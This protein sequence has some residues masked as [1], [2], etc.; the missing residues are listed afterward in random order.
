MKAMNVQEAE[1][2]LKDLRAQITRHAHQYYVLDDP[3]ISDG[4]Y[5]QLFRELLDL[6]EQFPDL[7][8]PDSPSLRVGGEPL[9]AFAEAE[10]AV[11]MLSLDNVFNAQEL[12]DFEEKIQR[13]LQATTQPTYL[14][15]PKLDGLAV[16][17]IYE[18]G[19]LVQGSTRGNGLVGENITAQLQTVQ[20]IPL[21]LVAQEG[22]EDIAIP[23]KLVVRGE[24]FL[25]RKGFLQLN[26]Q[27]A[28]QGEA[29]FANPRNAA[30]GSLRQLDPK[31]TASRPLR[32]YV[33]GVGDTAPAPCADLEQLFSWL[34]Q[35]GF[36]V[37]SLIKFCS[38][39]AEV[40]EQYQHLQAIRHELEYEIDGMVIKVADFALQQRLGNTTRAPRWATAWKFP[41]TQA[42]TVMTGVDFQV[43]RTGA[44]TPVAIL[45][46]VAV[47][48]VIVRRATLHNQDE[49]ERKGLKIGDTVLIQR[50]GDVIP[51]IVKPIIEQRSGA[52]QPIPFPSQ[53][54][55]CTSPLQRPEGEAVTRCINLHC[56]AQQLQRMIYFVGKAGLDIDGFGKKNVEQLLEVGLI[57]EIPDIFRLRKEQ[58]AVLDGWG[59]KSAEK[60][61]LAI[62]EAK[63]PTLARFIGALGIRYVGEMTSELLTRHFSSLDALLA[64][65]KEDLLAVEGIGE[66]AAM[67]LTEYF[68][69]SENRKMIETLLGLGLTIETTVQGNSENNP[70]EGAIFLFTG[71]LSQM[72]RNE[73]K[74]LVKDRGGRVVSGL[75]KQVT[76][77][78]AG[79]KA[80]SKLKKAQELGVTVVGEEEFLGIVGRG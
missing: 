38:T 49:I 14:A 61:L 17:L 76:H 80:G 51:E 70:L 75:S 30:A 79:E 35:L 60:L 26:E 41:A 40:E 10:H 21:R 36:P 6:E 42:T 4:E 18:N 47:E 46:P 37:N 58:L 29:L 16:E 63:H 52:E 59:E 74:Q 34:G 31:V 33:Y 78:V 72:S 67:S 66:Q 22:Q 62:D 50:A 20:S 19:L 65:E 24:V 3:L 25:P 73:A 68:S 12:K 44:I 77:L 43:G 69:N 7:V 55:V 2:R 13:Y 71:T 15:E 23:E 1:K 28:K 45:E 48:G 27:R 57:R 8:T 11:P 32:F 9:A 5:D 56:P 64:A 54:P 53:C 39:L